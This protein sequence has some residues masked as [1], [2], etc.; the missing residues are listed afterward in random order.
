MANTGLK[1]IVFSV[2]C[3][4]SAR[5]ARKGLRERQLIVEDLKLKGHGRE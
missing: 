4:V 2:G 5:V 1:V 3:K